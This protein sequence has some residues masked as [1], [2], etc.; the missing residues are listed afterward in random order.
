[1]IL[2]KASICAS[3]DEGEIVVKTLVDDMMRKLDQAKK[4]RRKLPFEA[5]EMLDELVQEFKAKSA[6]KTEAKKQDK[7]P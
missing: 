6:K 5:K 4:P 3:I 2:T 1:M 7:K